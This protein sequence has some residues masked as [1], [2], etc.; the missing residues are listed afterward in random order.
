MSSETMKGCSLRGYERGITTLGL[1]WLLV[2]TLLTV[3]SF[4]GA[5]V[6][7]FGPKQYDRF[8]GGPNVYTDTFQRCEPSDVALLR[9]SNGNGKDTTVTSGVIRINGAVVV[10]ESDFKNQT[11]LV[12]K[13][14]PVKQ[15]NELKVELKSA[16]RE[17]SFVK[18]EIIGRNCDSLAP[19]IFAPSPRDAAL[20]R[21]PRP[22][23]AASY[24]DEANGSGI[25]PASAMLTVDGTDVTAGATIDASGITYLPTADLSPGEHQAIL[26]I[27]DRAA[28]STSLV[29]HFTIDTAPIVDSTPP[30]I[31]LTSPA[32]GVT[33]E[34]GAAVSVTVEATDDLFAKEITLTASGALDF[35]QTRTNLTGRSF[36]TSFNLDIPTEITGAGTI[37]LS[38][39][40]KDASGNLSTQTPLILTIR[41][42]IAPI[43]IS[44]TP[45]GQTAM[46]K[47]G[48]YGSASFTFSDNLGIT[49]VSCTASGA[50]TGSQSFAINPPQKQLTQLFAFDVAPG[51]ASNAAIT[52]SCTATDAAAN[53]TLNS[54]TLAVAD[55]VSPQVTIT[56]PAEETEVGT[57][58]TVTVD[59]QGT[60]DLSVQEI[61]LATSGELASF[62]SISNLSGTNYNASFTLPV[63]A[64]ITGS[65]TIQLIATIKDS[66]GNASSQTVQS[67]RRITIR[68]SIAP[69]MVSLDSP[70]ETIH[71]QPGEAGSA[72]L[73]VSD[74]IGVT[75][76]SCTASGAATGSES[77]TIAPASKQVTRVFAFQVASNATP[78]AGMAVTCTVLDAAGN[79]AA[80]TLDLTVAPD[81]VPP[82]VT[83]ASL[84]DNASDVPVNAAITVTFSEALA[85]A[86]VSGSSV[87]MT[88]TASGQPVAGIVTLAPDRRS[89][90]FTPATPFS[91]GQ[92]YQLNIGTGMTDDAGNLLPAH[93]LLRFTT[94]NAAATVVSVS[95]AAGSTNVPIRTAIEITFSEAIDPASLTADKLVLSSSFGGVSGTITFASAGNSV[96]LRPFGPLGYSRDYTVTVKAGVKDLSGNVTS[97]DYNFSFKTQAASPDLVGLWTM[98]GDWSDSSGKGNNGTQSGGAVFSNDRIGGALSGSFDGVNDHVS[99]PS[100]STLTPVSAVSVDAWVK[101]A[102]IATWHQVVTK[103]FAESADPYNSFALSTN[104]GGAT[105]K[106]SFYVSNGTAGSQSGVIDSEVIVPD[107]W[108]HLVGTYDGATIKLY[109]NGVLKASKSK[110][111]DVAYS[112]LPLR[113]G[114]SNTATGQY[115]KGLIDE[116]AVYNRAL[117]PEDALEHYNAHVSDDQTPPAAPTVDAIPSQTYRNLMVLNGTKD[118]DASIRINGIQVV[119]HDP[120]TT[121][122]LLYSLLPGENSL[123]IVSHDQAGNPSETIRMATT[124]LPASQR[125]ADI[126]GSWHMDGY[127]YDYSGNGNHGTPNNGATFSG[128]RIDDAKSVNFDGVNDYV[129]MVDTSTLH[130]GRNLTITGWLY[131]NSFDKTW[132]TVF[133]KGNTPDGTTG[134]REYALWVNS[135]GCLQL[136]STPQDKAGVSQVT[137]NTAAGVVQTGRWQ[138]FAAVVS[139]DQNVMKIYLDGVERATGAYSQADIRDT[140][141]PLYLGNGLANYGSMLNGSIDEVT[142]YKRALSIQEISALSSAVPRVV[143]ASPGQ[144]VAYRPGETG[145]ATVTMTD[146]AGVRGMSCTASGAASGSVAVAYPS[147][148]TAATEELKFQVAAHAAPYASIPISCAAYD[149]EGNVG[150]ASFKLVVADTMLPTVIS[151]SIQDNATNV[152][153]TSSVTVTFSEAMAAGSINGA[154]FVLAKDDGSGQTAAGT[155]TQSSDKKSINF[156]PVPALDGSASYKLTLTTA[157]TDQAGNGLASDHVVRFSTV[158]VTEVLIDGKGT[159]SAP[160]AIGTGRYSNIQIT[161]SYVALTG[162]VTADMFS[163]ANNS[164]LT[165]LQTG[166][167]GA[168]RLDLTATTLNIDATSRI[169]VSRKGYLGGYSGG[170]SLGATGRTVGNTTTGGSTNGGGYGGLGGSGNATYGDYDNPIDLGSGGVGYRYSYGGSDTYYAGGNGGGYVKIA[171]ETI[172]LS[173]TILA[174]GGSVSNGYSGAGSG[175]GVRI[176]AGTLTGT[177]IISAKG[178]NSSN[179]SY[180]G[181]GGRIAVYYDTIGLP[182]ANI[183]AAG[184]TA[185]DMTYTG[186]AGTVYL[187]GKS[188]ATGTLFVD[189]KNKA[190]NYLSTPLPAVGKEMVSS[191]TS[192]TLTRSSGT[193]QAGALKGLKVRPDLTRDNTF[194][195]IDNT[196]TTLT[197]DPADGDLTQATSVGKTYTG[198]FIAA[199]KVVITGK[200]WVSSADPILLGAETT[201]GGAGLLSADPI[202]VDAGNELIIDGGT[203]YGDTNGITA[204]TI[205]VRNGGLI[206]HWGATNRVTH[207]LVLNAGTL[208]LDGTSKINVSG[209]GYIG[210]YPGGVNGDATGR[211]LGNLAGSTTSNGGS[212][213]GLGGGGSVNALY[214]S[215][216]DPVDLGSGGGGYRYLYG[217]NDS[218][219]AGGSGGGH[220]RITAGTIN[221]AGSILADGANGNS[222]SGAG[223]GGGIRLSV[224]MLTGTGTI[225]AKGGTSSSGSGG[226]GRIAVYYDVLSFPSTKISSAG[227]TAGA[228]GMAGTVYLHQ[229]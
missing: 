85:S 4:A 8:K 200:A 75:G 46:C 143:L 63:P 92:S 87:V 145:T 198:V 134:N 212:Y 61:T 218:Y 151:T 102:D 91:T 228:Y 139:S 116:V 168:E 152:A 39:V 217:G 150:T 206:T 201:I 68:D 11:F 79:Q 190:T 29:W 220:V 117:P 133:W 53:Q 108:T 216:F 57:G 126:L 221:L 48:E 173:G 76:V 47:P 21:I 225:S 3:N 22:T 160:V 169:D 205:T 34:L 96:S 204:D 35:V 179:Y 157:L 196:A 122:Q 167:S 136:N 43:A 62:Q 158:P 9:V 56:S 163:I 6:T 54:L 119:G 191:L 128:S 81:L 99:M 89:I 142:M 110:T 141:G 195:I 178:G 170:A 78:R 52:V 156:T 1:A 135:A 113:I 36:S 24:R 149:E 188:L 38:A 171:A 15:L 45:D 105:N 132:Q 2:L 211:T 70:G 181:G 175:G 19:V 137:L 50:A 88:A 229:Q 185:M 64:E 51:V 42:S 125:D 209:K 114:T 77:F 17:S 100:S 118:A 33:V 213:G 174:D 192:T 124:V 27:A 189:N 199:D 144:S 95:P 82:Q 215:D 154:S 182:I 111:G 224:G 58:S 18:I 20:L 183:T 112:T 129:T 49:G 203:L 37:Q 106:W 227:G 107:V 131:V 165:H 44:A 219:Y 59:V 146:D 172:N 161:N 69:T 177:G 186:G 187:K 176:D 72:S 73:T 25:D 140:T 210:G 84:I 23:I 101:P 13:A 65:G 31:S 121:W 14:I 184:G 222:Y 97:T 120:S 32:N 93:Y 214:G 74:N 130:A 194:T 94:D 166:T 90:T 7:V 66:T 67:V 41:D 16:S 138:H 98:D 159:S 30:R 86:T 155:F 104:A 153:A 80:K 148:R 5:D 207:A 127:W 83:G 40:A 12:E 202:T 223:S 208:S 197:V 115:F 164:T 103:R 123:E 226:G 26:T 55:T 28:N 10:D 193:W 71:Y 109:V 60:D 162:P 180:A 147:G